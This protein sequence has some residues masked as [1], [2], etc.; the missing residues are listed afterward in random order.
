MELRITDRKCSLS[1]SLNN[2]L[3]MALTLFCSIYSMCY[4]LKKME[5]LFFLQDI[6]FLNLGFHCLSQIHNITITRE[7]Q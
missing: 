4:N 3:S 2:H 6:F 7:W 5:I 1:N